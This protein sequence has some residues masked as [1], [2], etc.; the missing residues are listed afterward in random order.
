M[1]L[2]P[3]PD[4]Q[5]T[6]DLFTTDAISLSKVHMYRCTAMSLLIQNVSNALQK[7][8]PIAI[9]RTQPGFQ[10]R[11]GQLAEFGDLSALQDHS[12]RGSLELGGYAWWLPS[13]VEEMEFRSIHD[14]RVETQLRAAGVFADPL[15][16]LM[17]T[18]VMTIEFYSPLQIFEHEIGPPLTDD[19][20]AIYHLLNLVPAA[21]C[22]P[23]HKD[24]LSKV[25]GF[26][27]KV[28]RKAFDWV[29]NNPEEAKAY[30]LALGELLL[31]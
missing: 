6:Y 27:K 25:L 3:I 21:M 7:G 31:L 24:T 8:G 19:F 16:S 23:E 2:L 13:D 12:Y 9:A 30:A 20:M 1:V 28:G 29:V 14:R 17:I 22:N 4:F 10:Y 15:A 18:C 5:D 11:G 26:G